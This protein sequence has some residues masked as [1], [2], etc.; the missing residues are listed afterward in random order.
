[1]FCCKLGIYWRRPVY[2][3]KLLVLAWGL[4]LYLSKDISA[5]WGEFKS[6]VYKIT[7]R[8]FLSSLP[9]WRNLD[10]LYKM[11][12]GSDRLCCT[13]MK[14]QNIGGW[15]TMLKL[16]HH[17]LNMY[18]QCW[19]KPVWFCYVERS[20][21]LITNHFAGS[22]LCVET[23]TWL[24]HLTG[25]NKI[26]SK[27]QSGY[28]RSVEI[29]NVL[30]NTMLPAVYQSHS[31]FLKVNLLTQSSGDALKNEL[32][33][34]IG[35]FSAWL[36]DVLWPVRNHSVQAFIQSINASYQVPSGCSINNTITVRIKL[37]VIYF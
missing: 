12:W 21:F 1:M 24:Q 5:F 20:I 26:A 18:A 16:S 8:G 27:T 32:M 7:A 29:R 14:H 6:S 30:S 22:L 23:Q 28:S 13:T 33:S 35:Q 10:S 36:G 25:H 11:E 37:K 3:S 4:F 19:S 9:I 31:K 15:K 34:R 17:L 2:P